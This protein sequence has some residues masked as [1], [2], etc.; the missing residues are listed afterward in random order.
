MVVARRSK[1]FGFGLMILLTGLAPSPA[2]AGDSSVAVAAK[3]GTLG[4]GAD[5]FI[6]FGG[7]LDG[8]VGFN[9]F[10]Y[11]R[12]STWSDVDYDSDL[13]LSS[14]N[15]L[16][17]WYPTAGNFRVTFGALI[18]SNEINA[19]AVTPPGTTVEIGG[20]EYPAEALGELRGNVTFDELAP[21]AGIGFGNPFKAG[22]SWRFQFDVGVVYQ[23]EGEVRLTAENPLGIPGLEDSLRLEEQ[24]IQDDIDE[25]TLYPVLT[26]GVS[27]RF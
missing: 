17:D 15:L 14:F 23:G 26:L 5:L 12:D 8:R 20:V 4:A 24:E 1:L 19:V 18:N 10:T 7:H 3:A 16:L 2:A 21:Y 9:A 11:S 25:Y 27:Y 22:S 6:R 13:E